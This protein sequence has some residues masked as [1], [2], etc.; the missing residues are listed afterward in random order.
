MSTV[1]H[2]LITHPFTH[3]LPN[4]TPACSVRDWKASLGSDAGGLPV[5][6]VQVEAGIMTDVA[7]MGTLAQ[8][9][10]IL[11]SITAFL[12][13][14]PVMSRKVQICKDILAFL[15]LPLFMKNILREHC[16][17]YFFSCAPSFLEK[18]TFWITFLPK[19]TSSH[20]RTNSP[21]DTFLLY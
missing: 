9:S 2:F 1:T 20:E 13:G 4:V 11:C 6:N 3:P 12:S 15:L 7:A 18:E 19:F 8:H 5:W 21:R 10:V 16:S 17:F 14:E